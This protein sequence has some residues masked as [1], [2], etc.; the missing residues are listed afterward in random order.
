MRTPPVCSRRCSCSR[1]RSRSRAG[2]S[3]AGP[4]R[5][6]CRRCCGGAPT[7]WPG[8]AGVPVC[9]GPATVRVVW[10]GVSTT[11][12]GWRCRDR[13][14]ASGS[15]AP[16]P[17][18]PS[19]GATS[20]WCSTPGPRPSR[21]P[22]RS[23]ATA[24]PC[25][26]PTRR[27]DASRDGRRCWLRSP[28]RDRR[29]TGCS[30]SRSPCPTT[31]ERSTPTFATS[32]PSPSTRRRAARTRGCSGS[33]APTPPAM[34][35]SSRCRSAWR[36]AP[37]RAG[38]RDRWPPSCGSWPTCVG[39]S[40]TP[41]SPAGAHSIRPRSARCSGRS[42]R[43]TPRP[44]L[45]GHSGRRAPVP[46]VSWGCPGRWRPKRS[47]AASGPTRTWHATYWIAEWPRIDVGPDFLAPLLL[48]PLRRSV[49]VVM[50][51]VSPARAVRASRAGAHRRHRRLRAASSWRLPV[52]GPAR[53]RGGAGRPARDR[54]G[55]RPRLL[56]VQRL[57]HR[58]RPV[59][60]PARGV[61]RDDRA[62]RRPGPARA[63][64]PLRGPGAGPALHPPAVPGAL[65]SR[66]AA[67]FR[68]PAHAVTT[69]NLGAAYPLVAEAGL[70]HRGVL[71]GHDLLGGSFVYDPF[72]L[73]GTGVVSNP[74][75][76]VF[77]QIGRGKSALMKTYLWRQAVFGRRAWVVDPKGEYAGLA[78]L[79][80]V[81]PVALRSR[82]RGPAQPA[83]PGGAAGRRRVRVPRGSRTP[84]VRAPGVPGQ[85]VPR[86]SAARRASG[87]RSTS[88]SARSGPPGRCPRSRRWSP[89][90]STPT[91]PR[92]RAIR[93]DRTRLLEDGRDVAL[94]LR[95]L[96]DGD[97]RGMFDGETSPG[98]DLSG[99]LVVLDLSALYASSA[100]GV[101]MACATAWLQA[102]AVTRRRD[103]GALLSRGRRGLGDPR[104]PR[105]RPLAAG[106]LEAVAGPRR[107]QRRGPA[108]ALRPGLGG[109]RRLRAGRAG[110]GAAERL[111]DPGDL[112][113]AAGRGRPRHRA[114]VVVQ[115]RGRA[116]TAA[117]AGG[118]AVEGGPPLL[119]RPARGGVR[120]AGAR[121]H[122]RRDGRS[123][124]R[125]R[126]GPGP[127][128]RPDRPGAGR[129]VRASRGAGRRRPGARW[130]RRWRPR[131]T[132]PRRAG[133]PRRSAPSP[134]G[135]R[136]SGSSPEPAALGGGG[137]PDPERQDDGLAVPGHPRVAGAGA[138]GEREDR[139]PRRDTS[140][141]A[142]GSG[143]SG[144]SIR[145]G[146]PGR[147]P[148][149]GRHCRP[150]RP[151]RGRGGWPPT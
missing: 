36:A 101:L 50:E 142:A 49:S 104:Q 68:V 37:A 79:W 1:P 67:G 18:R 56:P 144:A 43:R 111:G 114:A 78:E 93:T 13:S 102:A 122:R 51:P 128:R 48:G 96:V 116:R 10:A 141:G 110:R 91:R 59:G 60:R 99:P 42:A 89:R 90:C 12:P 11:A 53:P 39:W 19:P 38:W 40:A 24:S 47:G 81:H 35:S 105:R 125:P 44:S 113:A 126:L 9:R 77:G 74:N 120:R 76:I 145:P 62:R 103:P 27:T 138:G 26:G 30:G 21:R 3:G 112:R 148:P 95:R 45:L 75:M 58:H 8:G 123:R 132:R 134:A 69:R 16:R 6:G 5:S 46:P 92:P 72:E 64:P 115:H 28:A 98:L 84:A 80:G 29:C 100:L 129:R 106:L 140:G 131:T 63:A 25:S 71:I 20:A 66:A 83:G 108:P 23:R 41:T 57:R 139:P 119:P 4:A 109:G 124:E 118:R 146:R 94:E 54:A 33:A 127:G 32:R 143:P 73:Y 136:G 150:P 61:V 147:R 117:P 151:G 34:P 31:G 22:W 133:A 17:S 2:R 70:G 85:R 88:R 52:D 130:A 7:G 121:R 149:G 55:R 15:S 65:V 14:P 87:R 135:S 107:G 82:G 137:R 86:P 97:L